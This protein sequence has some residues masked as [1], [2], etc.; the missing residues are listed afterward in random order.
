MSSVAVNAFGSYCRVEIDKHS[1][2][3]AIL[4]ADQYPT[5]FRRKEKNFVESIKGVDEVLT[6]V[7]QDQ[8]VR[9]TLELIKPDIFAK[10][11]YK[12]DPKTFQKQTP[13]SSSDAN[14]SQ[15]SEETELYQKTSCRQGFLDQA[16]GLSESDLELMKSEGAI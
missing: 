6:A 13:V 5:P 8:T 14:W 3:S 16:L 9:K 12:T 7:D 10:G 15:T 1:V 4:I 11:G 2:E